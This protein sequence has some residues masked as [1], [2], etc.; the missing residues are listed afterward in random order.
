MAKNAT[1][2]LSDLN[3]K[4][5]VDKLQ[6]PD[7]QKVYKKPTFTINYQETE[8]LNLKQQI[9]SLKNDKKRLQLELENKYANF[10]YC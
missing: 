10:I 9:D 2:S 7:C 5:S 6:C 4:E 3:K 1:I 8:L